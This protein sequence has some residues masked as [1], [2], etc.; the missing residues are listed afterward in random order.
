MSDLDGMY[1]DAATDGRRVP[2]PPADLTARL[3]ILLER[4]P[5]LAGIGLSYLAEAVTG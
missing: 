2:R 5:D 3:T 1:L 4:R